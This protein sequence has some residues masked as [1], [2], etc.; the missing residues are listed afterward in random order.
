MARGWPEAEFK[1]CID[2]PDTLKRVQEDIVAGHKVHV[3]STP[4]VLVNN[5]RFKYWRF[6]E[7]VRSVLKKIK[8]ED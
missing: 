8:K 7:V 5:R 4:T 3:D 1:A 2:S 6:P